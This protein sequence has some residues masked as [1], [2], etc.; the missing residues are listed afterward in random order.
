MATKNSTSDLI[1]GLGMAMS[2]LQRLVNEITKQGGYEEMLHVLSTDQGKTTLEE[3]AKVIVKAQWK[4]PRSL[5]ERLA[6]EVSLQA[7]ADGA[8]VEHDSYFSWETVGLEEQFGIPVVRFAG[9]NERGLA[10]IPTVIWE[11]LK[12]KEVTHP[13]ILDFNG[14]P[15]VVVGVT[16]D[17]E[18]HWRIGELA[19][20]PYDTLSISPA[21]YFDLNR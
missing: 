7:F 12:T 1:S 13:M 11:Q 15:H 17:G 3:V 18:G 21:K 10:P 8:Y 16:I 4:V 20:G 19:S 2:F 9:N 14:E 6:G 5:I